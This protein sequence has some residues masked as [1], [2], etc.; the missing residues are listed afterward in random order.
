MIAHI[1]L[2]SYACPYYN[3]RGSQLV[4][5]LWV[6]LSQQPAEYLLVIQNWSVGGNLY[7]FGALCDIV[8]Q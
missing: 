6:F 5:M 3:S 8:N 7:Y 4:R 1:G 2:S